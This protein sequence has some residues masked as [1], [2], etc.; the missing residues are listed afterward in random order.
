MMRIFTV[1]L[2]I[3]FSYQSVNAQSIKISVLNSKEINAVTVSVKQG[4]YQLK[5]NGETLGEYR[6]GSIFHIS[7]FGNSLQVRDKRNMIG[8]FGSIEFKGIDQE[9]I[10]SLKAINPIIEGMDYDDDFIISAGKNKIQL[11]NKL[12][13]ENYIAAVIEAEGGNHAPLEYYK[14]QAVLIRTYTIK[15]MYKH[16]EEGFNLCDQV[17]CQAYKGR[18]SNNAV[19][20]N[21]AVSTAGK[22]LINA[23]SVMV[24]TPF[25]SNCGG[26][27]SA[28]G[29]VWQKDLPHLQSIKDPFC[30]K[31]THSAW[32]LKVPK[33]QWLKFINEYQN[34]NIDYSKYNF[35]FKIQ[36]RTKF[37]LIN[38]V[39]LN[40]RT[41]R[42]NFGLKS[43]FFSI[44]DNEDQII[45][46]G[47][48]YGHGVGM[49]Q[50]GAIEMAR[51]GYTWL[52]I[53]HFYFCDVEITDYRDLEIS[54]F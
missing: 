39:N 22:V 11:I 52:D 28:A 48:G 13:M 9:N 42:E 15:N 43:A 23:D 29:M 40:M 46:N 41:V 30:T 53:I 5:V 18:A 49:C 19:I 45:F 36:H 27:T 2:V 12:D 17:H 33:E 14:A 26:E 21:A 54:Q 47:K 4:K 6:K 50:E 35:T 16:G 20:L 25:H 37:V 8:D 3:S 34:D 51:V 38:G 32:T 31:S 44:T 7:R 1:F 24:M 10:I